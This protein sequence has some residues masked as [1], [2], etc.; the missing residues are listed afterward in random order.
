MKRRCGWLPRRPDGQAPVVWVS[1]VRTVGEP[2]LSLTEC[3]VSVI[4]GESWSY[5]EGFFAHLALGGD[6]DLLEW[7]ARRVDAYTLLHAE[8]TKEESK[9][10]AER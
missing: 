4:R 6:G 9:R 1:S 7:P 8:L 5:V 2:R 10:D 3:P